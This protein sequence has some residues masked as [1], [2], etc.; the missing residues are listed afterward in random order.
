MPL[1]RLEVATPV[2]A[3]KKEALIKAA[4]KIVADTTGKPEGYVMVTLAECAGS[5]A[6]QVGPVAFADV[7]GIGG[8]DKKTNGALS[9]ALCDLLKKDLNIAPDKVY[10]TFTDVP[11]T[12][13]GWKGNTFG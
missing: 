11:A 2:P 3:Q 13:W 4:S 1:L 10:L 7:R 12:N 8:L 9:K 5:L 6:G